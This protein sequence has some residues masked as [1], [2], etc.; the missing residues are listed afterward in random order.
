MVG[1]VEAKQ[2]SDPAGMNVKRRDSF[3][4]S[5]PVIYFFSFLEKKLGLQPFA[6]QTQHKKKWCVQ[7]FFFFIFGRERGEKN[8]SGR[9]E[10]LFFVTRRFSRS[11]FI[12]IKKQIGI[13]MEF[14]LL[15]LLITKCFSFEIF[16]LRVTR[17]RTDMEKGKPQKVKK[18]KKSFNLTFS[19]QWCG[20]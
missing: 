17:P 18:R 12:I 10:F 14:L 8:Q 9:F 2:K 11:A 5:L 7:F 19:F 3:P 13:T 16:Q 20:G 15:L 4:P 6:C 1:E